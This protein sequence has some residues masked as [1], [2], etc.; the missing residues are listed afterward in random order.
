MLITATILFAIAALGGL[1][2]AFIHFKRN[3]N[4]PDSIVVLHGVMA[5]AGLIV[6]AIAVIRMDLS[7]LAAWALGIFIFAALGGFFL[8][9]HHVR[10]LRLPSAVVVIHAVV[11]VIAFVLLLAALNRI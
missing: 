10:K 6:L 11:A 5:A 3:V 2:M 7:G 8:L 1:T 4:P 9:G